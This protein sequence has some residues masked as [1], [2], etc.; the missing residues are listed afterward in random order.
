MAAPVKMDELLVSWLGSD[1]VYD[2]VLKLIE[3][4]RMQ[5]KQQ[6]MIQ[7]TKLT[8]PSSPKQ[9]EKTN[10]SEAPS[11]RVA[12]PVFHPLKT[13]AG[14]QMRRR[15]TLPNQFETWEPISNIPSNAF[16]INSGQRSESKETEQELLL[17]V[18][19]Q[20]LHIVPDLQIVPSEDVI[21][22][23][24]EAFVSI[25]REICRF[26]SF[27]NAPLY[28]RI[29]NLW[30][31][32]HLSDSQVSVVT[33]KILEWFWKTEMEPFDL[34]ERFFRLVKQPHQ[35]C[36]LRDDFL[37][38]IKAL[39]NDHPVSAPTMFPCSKVS[40]FNISYAL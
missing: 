23:P 6:E 24:L 7:R 34:S 18:R 9:E 14:K 21:S 28:H 4:Y 5:R 1:E 37:P 22:F 33:L 19:D 40:C 27:F 39:L 26:P 13:T 10:S 8:P 30:N 32:A 12:I 20:V 25:T 38:F 31:T 16:G 15:R 35:D 17:C 3:E 29:L 2:N 36:I 11:H